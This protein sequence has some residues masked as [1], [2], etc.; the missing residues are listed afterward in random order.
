MASGLR[1][2]VKLTGNI[3][4]SDI[5]D[6]TITPA[7]LDTSKAFAFVSFNFSETSDHADTFR[8]WEILDV[9]TLRIHG[10]LGDSA[11][12][13]ELDFVAY[14]V[15]FK[16]S[17]DVQSDSFSQPA[18]GTNPNTSTISAV[19]LAESMLIHSGHNHNAGET[20]IGSEELE[21]VRL[22]NSTTWEWEV[23]LA[24]NTGPQI[25][26]AQIV[27]WNDSSISV[28]R[29]QA[30]LGAGSGSTT[31]TP[32]TAI[33]RTRT[34][35][36][37]SFLSDNGTTQAPEDYS[38]NA[39]INVSGDI[40]IS[41]DTG[42]GQGAVSFNWELVEF[43]ST[44]ATVQHVTHTMSGGTASN[45]DSITAVG[46][47]N[48]AIA[49][50]CVSTPFGF[51]WGETSEATG[52]DWGEATATI[53]L[54]AD[55]TVTFT[56]DTSASSYT[57]GYQVVE[58]TQLVAV[59][60][61]TFTV[62]AFLKALGD[63]GSCGAKI[64]SGTAQIAAADATEDVT[65]DAVNLSESFLIFQ[66]RVDSSAPSRFLVRGDLDSTT[67]IHFERENGAGTDTVVDITWYVVEFDKNTVQRG[68]NDMVDAT[69]PAV[70]NETITA[71]DLSRTFR[72]ASIQN[73]GTIW[74]IDDFLRTQLTSTTNLELS[75]QND[76]DNTDAVHWQV[77]E[78]AGANVQRGLVTMGGG[79]TTENV[80]L[81]TAVNLNRAI[82]II[83]SRA[84][85]EFSNGANA[86]LN[87]ELTTSTNLQI[88]R[89]SSSDAI[90]HDISWEVIEVPPGS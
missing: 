78:M 32:P 1:Q 18:S 49:I 85:G 52:G 63:N 86:S 50:S 5:E 43:P 12:Q 65:I 9:N 73:L 36:F 11:A 8:S 38:L 48:N 6:I 30:T 54:T 44:F 70:V 62:D 66:Y 19:N 61:K 15:E 64:Q 45:T 72:L 75:S 71:V 60:D 24:P 69:V 2:I 88:T 79:S 10:Q 83:D 67:N 84:N 35:L 7:L 77:V 22:L 4:G 31:V 23:A 25:N 33:D 3:S 28:Q 14:I 42:A 82:V 55:D 51:G 21:R 47:V 56:R 87:A 46:D 39:T 20:T 29:G 37:V 89:G 68:D 26:R 90:P 80:T 40:A 81:P 34:M 74:G 17:I 57:V 76:V 59:T 16:G 27:D 53:N 58:F 41:R 13:N